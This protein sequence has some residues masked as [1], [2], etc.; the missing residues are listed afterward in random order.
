MPKAVFA[1][2]RTPIIPGHGHLGEADHGSTRE[3]VRRR[4]D[5]ASVRDIHGGHHFT[6]AA[7]RRPGPRL[8]S[9]GRLVAESGPDTGRRALLRDNRGPV[10]GENR[11]RHRDLE[12]P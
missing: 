4:Q 9:A 8:V 5:I 12:P 7:H 2:D 3:R 11:L 6:A 10:R 1:A